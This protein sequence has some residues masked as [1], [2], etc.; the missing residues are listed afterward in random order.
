MELKLNKKYKLSLIVFLLAIV[1]VLAGLYF[2]DHTVAV[3]EP[4]GL[5]AQ[6]ERNL[7]LLALGLM[8]I[9]VIP[10]FILTFYT[11]HKYQEGH[12]GKYKPDF[13]HS[14]ILE[15][16][17]WL[18]P[19]VLI[20]V[21]SIITWHASYSLNPYKPIASKLPAL[22]IE[23][24][25]LDWKWLFI[26]P[27]QHVASVNSLVLPIKQPITF[28]L[29]S[30]APM[31]T[32]WIPQL[33][34]QIMCMP[35]MS[36]QINMIVNKVGNYYGSSGNI[37]GTGFAGMHFYARAVNKTAFRQWLNQASHSSL[38]LDYK[39]YNLLAKSSFNNPITYYKSPDNNLYNWIIEKY[40]A[41]G[42]N[43]N[44]NSAMGM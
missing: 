8:L 26:Y 12:K 5:I 29:T 43:L 17:W 38:T 4:Q 18:I 10:V 23:V 34:G 30:D 25:A 7:F 2:H 32:F 16:T 21:L 22:N 6:K 3:L 9:V 36:T 41:P 31:N 33:S 15:L 39:Q 35:G 1:I 11:V 13:D 28:Y 14:R 19:G 20:T 40:L 42:T 44:L 27:D 24:V 37:S